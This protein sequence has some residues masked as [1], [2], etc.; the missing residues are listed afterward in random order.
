MILR[1]LLI[2]IEIIIAYL[3]QSSVFIHF[4]LAGVVPDVLLILVCSV[5]YTRG[6]MSGLVCGFV[7]GLL[8]D[9]T[10]GSFIGLF[11][12]IY[13][14]IGYSCG[15]A[16]KIYK[17]ESY[18]FP[19]ILIGTAEFVFN[20]LYYFFFLFLNGK[21]N[22]GYYLF[23]TMIPRVIYTVTLS[24]LFY[25]L[26]NMQHVFLEDL[27]YRRTVRKKNTKN[28]NIKENL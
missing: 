24:L 11:A 21:L 19:Y 10:Y 15:Y 7:S 13:M 26:L 23:N 25:R 4:E 16:N 12:F 17:N 6:R 5:A 18:T 3:L 27:P 2:F 8:I 22:Y 9:C 14:T 1:I 20:I 28:G